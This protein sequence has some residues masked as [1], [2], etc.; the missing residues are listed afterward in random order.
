MSFRR[1]TIGNFIIE[2]GRRKIR[3][4]RSII[5]TH[6]LCFTKFGFACLSFTPCQ[7][8][9]PRGAVATCE[10]AFLWYSEIRWRDEA[11]ELFENSEQ[12]S[13]GWTTYKIVVMSVEEKLKASEKSRKKALKKYQ[14]KL[15]ILKGPQN[16]SRSNSRLN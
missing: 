13:G 4:G 10:E 8:S 15:L 3:R 12:R 5:T 11:R 9:S 1:A 2:E 16:F 6:R 14:Q 7:P